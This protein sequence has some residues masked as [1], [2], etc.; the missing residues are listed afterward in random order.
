MAHCSG[1]CYHDSRRGQP[2]EARRRR[3][4]KTCP[5]CQ[6]PFETGGRAG[7]LDQIYCSEQCAA[8]SKWAP[9]DNF[10]AKGR[11]G[12]WAELRARIVARDKVCVFCGHA[13]NL[14]V[15]HMVPREYDG[16]HDE[17]NLAAACRHCHG[18]VDRMI[19]IMKTKNPAFD[20]RSW[21][22]SF[23]ERTSSYA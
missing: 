17:D 7:D 2:C 23:M 19:K 10:F 22:A 18:A 16:S 20:I 11:S 9:I 14:Q 1:K 15:H 4:I 3:V 5:T 6:E 8:K 21:L 12:Y 13:E